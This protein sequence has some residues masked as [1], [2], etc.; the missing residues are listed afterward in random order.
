MAV[1]E[2]QTGLW[3]GIKKEMLLVTYNMT[4]PR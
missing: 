2:G 1:Q 3:E 4:A